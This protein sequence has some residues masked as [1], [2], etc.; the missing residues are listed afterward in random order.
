[1]WIGGR[2]TILL[3]VK[4]GNSSIIAT[5]AVVT[6]DVPDYA[7]VGGNPARILKYRSPE[8]DISHKD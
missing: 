5:C 8:P 6:R 1:M 4:I 7:I 2:V 3:G